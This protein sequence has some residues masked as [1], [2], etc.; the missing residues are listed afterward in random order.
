VFPLSEARSALAWGGLLRNA[1][2]VIVSSAVAVRNISCISPGSGMFDVGD[3]CVLSLF[4]G[5]RGSLAGGFITFTT[6]FRLGRFCGGA[7]AVHRV[8][9]RLRANVSTR[10]CTH[11]VVCVL[12]V[13]TVLIVTPKQWCLLCRSRCSLSSFSC[14]LSGVLFR[15]VHVAC[16]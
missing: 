5:R 10:V 6:G 3:I 16:E 8:Q 9:S 12:S 13:S 11:V 1:I 4:W 2:T 15:S 7:S 14:C